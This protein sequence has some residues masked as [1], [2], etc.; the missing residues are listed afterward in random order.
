MATVLTR[1]L[2]VYDW[3]MAAHV[4][5]VKEEEDLEYQLIYCNVL[6]SHLLESEIKL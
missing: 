3:N 1:T 2:G 5:E 4:R 6:K